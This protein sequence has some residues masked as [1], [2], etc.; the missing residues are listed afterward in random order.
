MLHVLVNGVQS[1][2]THGEKETEYA[3]I[4]SRQSKNGKETH[5]KTKRYIKVNS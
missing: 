3:G 1:I 5:S 2:Q 4:L